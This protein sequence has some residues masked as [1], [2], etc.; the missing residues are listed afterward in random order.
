VNNDNHASIFILRVFEPLE[1]GVKKI[2]KMFMCYSDIFRPKKR[3]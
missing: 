3:L 1:A 2:K